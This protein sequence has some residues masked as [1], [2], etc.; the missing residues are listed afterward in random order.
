M[1]ACSGYVF[2]ACKRYGAVTSLADY[3]SLANVT[4]MG[5]CHLPL[6]ELLENRSDD[7]NE[8]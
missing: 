5:L 6:Q 7:L 8:T 3:S 1:E 4:S 2:Y